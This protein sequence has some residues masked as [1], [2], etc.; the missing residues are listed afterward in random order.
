[1][2]TP[3]RFTRFTRE[4][5]LEINAALVD[6]RTITDGLCPANAAL[7]RQARFSR[8]E[9]QDAFRR[10]RIALYGDASTPSS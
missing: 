7:V 9:I 5:V 3:D 6:G 2:P 4:D 10:A 1:M 8:S